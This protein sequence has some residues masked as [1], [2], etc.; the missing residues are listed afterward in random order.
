[1]ELFAEKTKLDNSKGI[2]AYWCCDSFES[3]RHLLAHNYGQLAGKI[4]EIETK[5]FSA[6]SIFER[7]PEILSDVTVVGYLAYNY[8]VSATGIIDHLRKRKD[9]L[10]EEAMK[11]IEVEVKSISET[12]EHVFVKALS[13][14]MKHERIPNFGITTSGERQDKRHV[15]I[16]KSVFTE[17]PRLSKVQKERLSE[18]KEENIK[19][20]SIFDS[21]FDNQVKLIERIIRLVASDNKEDL[22]E[23]HKNQEDYRAYCNRHNYIFQELYKRKYYA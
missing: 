9:F 6:A 8:V 4:K 17:S 21:H 1:M 15:Y 16:S 5:W 14:C 3:S 18:I 12:I 2:P 20:A 11:A 23:L 10:T 7:S 13:G 22:K 19:V